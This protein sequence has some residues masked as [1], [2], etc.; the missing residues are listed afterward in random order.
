MDKI[1]VENQVFARLDALTDNGT[2]FAG[3]LKGL[4]ML[5]NELAILYREAAKLGPYTRS[6]RRLNPPR[7]AAIELAAQTMRFMVECL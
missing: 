3:R 7:E 4:T 6:N 2:P 1:E 5:R